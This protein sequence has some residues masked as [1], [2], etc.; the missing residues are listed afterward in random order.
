MILM[1]EVICKFNACKSNIN[2]VSSAF[3][4]ENIWFNKNTCYT[5]QNH[6]SFLPGVKVDKNCKRSDYINANDK[7]KLIN[8]I[9]QKSS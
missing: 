7:L 2:L 3:L 9:T 1:L 6:Y 5:K 8:D 4:Q